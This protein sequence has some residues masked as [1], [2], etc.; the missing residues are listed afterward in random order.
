[1]STVVLP[2]S[3][4][5]FTLGHLDL[6]RRAAA[7]GHHVII[8]VSHNPSKQGTLDL[9]TRKAAITTTLEQEDLSGAVEVR[10][11]PRGL[12]VDFCR[13]VGATAVI[14]GLRSQ[15]DLAY[16]EPMARMNHHLA[17]VDTVFLLTDSAW[18]HISSSLV[19]EVHGLGGDV[20]DMLPGPSLD[21][22][23]AAA[24]VS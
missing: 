19:R 21:A 12:L 14:R 9:E 8:A 1:M 7:L 13:E 15:L 5:P 3:F 23:R 6:T 22:L 4:D 11:L 16:E 24:A 17:D 10:T 20:S 18:S 2:G